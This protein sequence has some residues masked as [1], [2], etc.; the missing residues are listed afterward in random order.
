MTWTSP[1]PSS[2]AWGTSDTSGNHVTLTTG[3]SSPRLAVEAVTGFS[4]G[5]FF[6]SSLLLA[7]LNVPVVTP[8]TGELEYTGGSGPGGGST[9]PTTGMLYPRGQG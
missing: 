9:R 3:N 2:P 1:I 4:E 8:F 6:L 5:Q 7:P